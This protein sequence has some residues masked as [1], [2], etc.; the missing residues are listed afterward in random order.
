MVLLCAGRERH[1]WVEKTIVAK[2]KV[3]GGITYGAE[4]QFRTVVAATSK[5]KAA[6]ILNITIYQMNSWWTETFNKYEVEAAMSEPGAIFQ[7]LSM[8]EA[9][10]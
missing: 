8:A 3:Y 5:S 2:L 7:S 9:H 1:I 10:L 4:G 6:S